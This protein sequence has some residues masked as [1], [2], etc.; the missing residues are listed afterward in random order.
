MWGD[1]A[2][3]QSSAELGPGCADD[4]GNR[5]GNNNRVSHLERIILCKKDEDGASSKIGRLRRN[6]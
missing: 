5:Q 1:S 3:V 2:V 4:A 6:T